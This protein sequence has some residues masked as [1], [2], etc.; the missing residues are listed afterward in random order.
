MTDGFRSWS[1]GWSSSL[2][3]F[4]DEEDESRLKELA[5]DNPM[6]RQS[7]VLKSCITSM[8]QAAALAN[9]EADP[10]LLDQR[11]ALAALVFNELL[12]IFDLPHRADHF[13]AKLVERMNKYF[14]DRGW[15]G[16]TAD[17]ML[18]SRKGKGFVKSNCCLLASWSSPGS[19]KGRF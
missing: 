18:T 19:C 4:L 3:V 6:S 16:P 14:E 15:S 2:S 12:T 13:E 17:P 8:A 1:P 7:L 11:L 9:V 5:S 10:E